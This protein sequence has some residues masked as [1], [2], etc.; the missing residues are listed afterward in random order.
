VGGDQVDP[1]GVA[2]FDFSLFGPDQDER[3]QR[4]HF[5]GHQKHHR[6]A[7]D[8]HEHH[9]RRE[10]A[11]AQ[12]Q[13]PPIGRMPLLFP[14]LQPVDR[15]ERCDEQHRNKKPHA[16]RIHSDGE[17]TARQRPLQSQFRLRSAG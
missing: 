17:M 13:F 3:R 16:Q 8:H 12:P 11:P 4:H 1:G 2:D 15:A 10:Q 6:V 5:P 7:R 14:V 9:A